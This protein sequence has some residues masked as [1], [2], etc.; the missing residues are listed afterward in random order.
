MTPLTTAAM[1]EDGESRRR[2]APWVKCLVRAAN[3]WH[4]AGLFFVAVSPPMPGFPPSAL[5]AGIHDRL[6]RAQTE[7]LGLNNP[8]RYYAPNVSPIV[9]AWFRVSLTGGAIRW[10]ELPGVRN[11]L[12]PAR[13]QQRMMISMAVQN[14]TEVRPEDPG[15]Q[16]RSPFGRILLGSYA[17]HVAAEIG[18]ADRAVAEVQIYGVVHRIRRPEEVRR[19][20]LASDLRLFAPRYLGSFLPDG[21]LKTDDASTVARCPAIPMSVFAATVLAED[22]LPLVRDAAADAATNAVEALH[23][24]APIAQL[25]GKNPSLLQPRKDDGLRQALVTAVESQD[26]T[27]PGTPDVRDDAGRW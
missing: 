21:S 1:R 7:F 13:H 19:G 14:T 25:I 8:N 4:F 2:I 11:R 26:A 22:V 6:F 24:P 12:L 23:I 9:Q 5:V 18:R 17:R 3:L 20:W 15:E 16:F 10:M 27:T